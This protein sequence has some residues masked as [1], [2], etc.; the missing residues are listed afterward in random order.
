MHRLILV[1]TK[2]NANAMTSSSDMGSSSDSSSGS[3]DYDSDDC[4][5][6]YRIF[7]PFS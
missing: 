7:Y 3:M 6:S 1:E 5:L 4:P 2:E